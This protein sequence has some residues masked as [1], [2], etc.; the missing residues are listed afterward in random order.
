MDQ[1]DT[2]WA[3][4][5]TGHC[6]RVCPASHS[7]DQRAVKRAH[8]ALLAS[9]PHGSVAADFSEIAKEVS[10]KSVNIPFSYNSYNP[11]L[12][13]YVYFSSA[14]TKES[15]MRITCA[16]KSIGLT[17]HEPTEVSFLYHRCGRPVVIQINVSHHVLLSVPLV[18]GLA[19]I[20]CVNYII[21]T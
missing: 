11:K 5:C 10:A 8:V 13:A 18:H 19:M 14:A 12:Y 3:V 21:N 20:N 17:W 9:L 16:L 1:F 6:L 4:L 7:P 15:A 2:T